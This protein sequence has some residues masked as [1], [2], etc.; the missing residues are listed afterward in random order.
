MCS[1]I[2][3]SL[4]AITNKWPLAL[5]HIW[6]GCKE[7]SLALN[8]NC[9]L[10]KLPQSIPTLLRMQFLSFHFAIPK[11]NNIVFKNWK[12][13]VRF[14][15]VLFDYKSECSREWQML[16]WGFEKENFFPRN[17]FYLITSCF[18]Q[19]GK[20]ESN[21]EIPALGICSKVLLHSDW[22]TG[23]FTESAHCLEYDISR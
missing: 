20:S 5:A 9:E 22:F 6:M 7:L 18:D 12:C 10:K 23:L 17:F 19:L 11:E 15:V 8:L 1:C 2:W 13:C 14:Y 4:K 3:T 21:Q 16:S